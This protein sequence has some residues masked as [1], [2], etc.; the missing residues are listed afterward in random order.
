MMRGKGAFVGGRSVERWDRWAA[1]GLEWCALQHA[2]CWG[3]RASAG[4]EADEVTRDVRSLVDEA[5]L[6]RARGVDP[7]WWAWV[8]WAVGRSRHWQEAALAD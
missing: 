2:W 8:V 5:A 6:A 1:C 3:D 7:W 4:L